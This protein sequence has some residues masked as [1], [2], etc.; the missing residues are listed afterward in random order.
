MGHK[1][2]VNLLNRNLTITVYSFDQVLRDYLNMTFLHSKIFEIEIAG[3]V[4]LLSRNNSSINMSC[5][6]GFTEKVQL[7]PTRNEYL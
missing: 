1:N 7:T 5:F 2:T 4:K 6:T 3:T